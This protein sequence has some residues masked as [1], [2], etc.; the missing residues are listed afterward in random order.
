MEDK[1]KRRCAIGLD[2]TPEIKKSLKL[3]AV[4]Q[5]LS[6]AKLV[7][8][9]ITEYVEREAGTLGRQANVS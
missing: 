6:V 2:I 1:K 3:L 4:H 5:D 9:I 7:L 8:K